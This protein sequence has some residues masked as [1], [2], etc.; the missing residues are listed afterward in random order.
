MESSKV[1]TQSFYSELLN[2]EMKINVYV[3]VANIVGQ[4]WPVLYFLHGRSGNPDFLFETGIHQVADM[5]LQTGKIRPL[6]IAFPQMDNSQGLNSASA[7][8]E[9]PDPEDNR[10]MIHL[11]MY[12]DYF[13]KEV[14]GFIESRYNKALDPGV[15]YIGGVSAGGYGALHIAFHHQELFSK[16]GGHMPALE[17]ELEEEDKPYYYN[18]QFWFDNDP[19]NIAKNSEHAGLEVYLDCGDRD[20]GEFYKGCALLHEVLAAKGV[21]TQNHVFKGEHDLAYIRSNIEKYL[22][23]Y[24]S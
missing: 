10:R 14:I 2:K 16:I 4:S 22:L 6:L 23:F 9:F 8:Q 24:G 17:L 13:L 20:Q 18:M 12:E 11:G 3:P 5:L 7:Y 15:R 1:Q 21:K 19:I